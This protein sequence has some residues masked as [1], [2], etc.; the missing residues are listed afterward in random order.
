MDEK[1]NSNMLLVAVLI[2]SVG[3]FAAYYYKTHQAPSVE[4]QPD[5]WNQQ[6]P[7]QPAPQ[8]QQP[9]Q[10]TPPVQP[11]TAPTAQP[12]NYNEAIAIAKQ[13]G[14]QIFLYFG[15]DWCGPCKEMKAKTFTDSNVQAALKN[16]VVLIADVK[17]ERAAASKFRVIAYPT[18]FIIDSN[19]RELKSAK[20][21]KTP[22]EFLAWLGTQNQKSD[23]RLLNGLR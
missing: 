11:E 5:G 10:P 14:K 16:Y 18:Y 1:M 12:R 3:L 22:A 7:T 8:P 20:G 17:D 19:E 13:S 21:F 15:A 4:P 6:W 2:L 9:P 23:R